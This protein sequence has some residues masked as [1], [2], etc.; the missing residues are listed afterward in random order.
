M[1]LMKY[2]QNKIR[3]LLVTIF[4]LFSSKL[5][6]LQCDS[7]KSTCCDQSC[8]SC[9]QSQISECISCNLN[10]SYLNVQYQCLKTCPQGTYLDLSLNQ[11]I[12]C[13]SQYCSQCSSSQCLQC[14][15]GFYS[16]PNNPQNCI[17]ECSWLGQIQDEEDQCNYGCVN[18]Q[19]YH[20]DYQSFSCQ[21]KIECPQIQQVPQIQNQNTIVS[22]LLDNN[23]NTITIIDIYGKVVQYSY[24]Y[25]QAQVGFQLNITSFQIIDCQYQ[26]QN[27]TTNN[28][29]TCLLQPLNL[30]KFYNS[31]GTIISQSFFTQNNTKNTGSFIQSFQKGKDWNLMLAQTNSYEIDLL[32]YS[33]LT[34]FK[35]D[36]SQTNQLQ[37]TQ[38]QQNNNQTS[39]EIFCI[40]YTSQSI[41]FYQVLPYQ[42][43]LAYYSTII[44]Q[45]ANLVQLNT[46]YN[47][48]L[49][50]STQFSLLQ[51]NSNLKTLT[52]LQTV[53][54]NNFIYSVFLIPQKDLIVIMSGTAAQN[55]LQLNLYSFEQKSNQIQPSQI[56]FNN[57]ISN[58]NQ[59]YNFGSILVICTTKDVK[60]YKFSSEYSYL[61]QIEQLQQTNAQLCSSSQFGVK[62]IKEEIHLWQTIQKNFIVNIFNTTNQ[63]KNVFFIA[64]NAVTSQV[65]SKLSTSTL[66]F[67]LLI[68]MPEIQKICEVKSYGLVFI[69]DIISKKI[70]NQIRIW[71]P[72]N[73]LSTLVIF[74]YQI[75][76]DG[77]Y[78]LTG[79]ENQTFKIKIINFK[80][81]EIIY[82]QSFPEISLPLNNFYQFYN[83]LY[84]PNSDSIIVVIQLQKQLTDVQKKFYFLSFTKNSSLNGSQKYQYVKSLQIYAYNYIQSISIEYL[85]IATCIN[86]QVYNVYIY[87]LQMNQILKSPNLLQVDT[88]RQAQINEKTNKLFLFN[89][90]GLYIYNLKT[91][92]YVFYPLSCAGSFIFSPN[93]QYYYTQSVC[94]TYQDGVFTYPNS[95]LISQGVTPKNKFVYNYHFFNNDDYLILETSQATLIYY[96]NIQQKLFSKSS[97]YGSNFGG[98]MEKNEVIFFNNQAVTHFD[99]NTFNLIYLED[100]VISK[101]FI[102]QTKFLRF[103]YLISTTSNIVQVKKVQQITLQVTKSQNQ[104]SYFLGFISELNYVVEILPSQIKIYNALNN[105]FIQTVIPQQS[106]ETFFL[107]PPY[108]NFWTQEIFTRK[109]FYYQLN[110]LIVIV[111]FKS[112]ICI[113]AFT[114]QIVFQ[115]K[116]QQNMQMFK[117]IFVDWNR[118]Y[119]ISIH[120]DQDCILD[121]QSLKRTCYKDN[122]AYQGISNFSAADYTQYVFTNL[123]KNMLI[124]CQQISVRV[125]DLDSL[126]YIKSIYDQD[127]NA[128]QFYYNRYH[129]YLIFNTKINYV[130]N[131]LDLS[132]MQKSLISLP[133]PS[134]DDQSINYRLNQTDTQAIQKYMIWDSYKQRLIASSNATIY[135]INTRKNLIELQ[136]LDTFITNLQLFADRNIIQYST[137]Y[138][139]VLLDY[140]YLLNDNQDVFPNQVN[141]RFFKV[142]NNTYFQL[143]D[144][145]SQANLFV[146]QTITSSWIRNNLNSGYIRMVENDL[147]KQLIYTI[148]D[149]EIAILDLSSQIIIEI[150][151][152]FLSQNIIKILHE[153]ED[154]VILL[155][156]SQQ[157]LQLQKRQTKIQLNEIIVLKQGVAYNFFDLNQKKFIFTDF[158][159]SQQIL[160]IVNLSQDQNNILKGDTQTYLKMPSRILS[161]KQIN[162]SQVII[163]M[164]DLIKIYD[165]SLMID[166]TQVGL[167][168]NIQFGNI[169]IDNIY[170][171]I[172]IQSQL[173]GSLIFDYNLKRNPN[174]FINS[175]STNLKFDDNF[176]YSVVY[177]STNIYFRKDLK[178]VFNF[179]HFDISLQLKN[180]SYLGVGYLFLVEFITKFSI[181]EFSPFLSLPAE[182]SFV[183]LNQ[184]SVAGFSFL[185][186]L[187]DSTKYQLTLNGFT[188]EGMFSYRLSLDIFSQQQT[189][190][191]SLNYSLQPNSYQDDTSLSQISSYLN[192]QERN[193]NGITITI[194]K[195]QN[196][197]IPQLQKNILNPIFQLIIATKEEGMIV[198]IQEPFQYQQGISFLQ[199]KN[200]EIQFSPQN[201]QNYLQNNTIPN[202]LAINNTIFP[203]LQHIL[204]QN[205][206]LREANIQINNIQQVVIQKINL[207]HFENQIL[208]SL[209]QL[210]ITNA[211]LVIVTE[212]NILSC[213]F[214]LPSSL[215][216]L[217]DIQKLQIDHIYISD[218]SFF[219]VDQ[220]LILD[221]IQIAE[222]QNISIFNTNF[223]LQTSF[224]ITSSQNIKLG[225]LYLKESYYISQS[226]RLLQAQKNIVQS[227][228][229][230]SNN[231][232][233]DFNNIAVDQF[234]IKSVNSNEFAFFD[235][236]LIYGVITIKQSQIEKIFN[237]YEQICTFFQLLGVYR[238][239]LSEILIQVNI[240]LQY[241][242][243]LPY[244]ITDTQQYQCKDIEIKNLKLN[245]SFI[246]QQSFIQISSLNILLDNIQVNNLTLA[247]SYIQQPQPYFISLI[248]SNSLII[249]NSQFFSINNTISGNI[250]IE[251]SNNVQIINSI[252]QNLTT[253]KT[254]TIITNNCDNVTI[255]NNTFEF[256]ITQSGDGGVLYLLDSQVNSLDS[257]QFTSNSAIL[258]SGGAIYC[259]GSIFATLNSNLFIKNKAIQSSGGAILLKNCDI[260]Q[261]QNNM[262]SQNQAFI[263]GAIRY[264]DL[265]PLA[266]MQCGVK[267]VKKNNSF[268]KNK[269]ISFGINI[270]SYP[271]ILDMKNYFIDSQTNSEGYL[272]DVQSGYKSK[273]PILMRF[274]D[275]EMREVDFVNLS[276]YPMVNKDIIQEMQLYTLQAESSEIG[277]LGDLRQVYSQKSFAFVFDLSYSYQPLSRATLNIRS[278]QLLPQFQPN[279]QQ[280]IQEYFNVPV[281]VSFRKCEVGEVLQK[282]GNYTLCYTCEQGFYSISDPY[283][284]T[285]INC[286]KC[287][288]GSIIC[289]GSQIQVQNGFWRNNNYS[290]I[291]VQCYYPEVCQ[292]EDP[293][294]KNGCIVG[295]TGPLCLECDVTGKVWGSQYSKVNQKA[296]SDCIHFLSPV[297][298]ALMILIL[299]FFFL[300]IYSKTHN[301]IILIRKYIMA[302]YLSKLRFISPNIQRT[303]TSQGSLVKILLNYFQ[304]LMIANSL[305]ITLPA[306]FTFF[307][308]T[309]GDTSQLTIYSIDCLL[310]SKDL[311]L[312]NYI[313][314]LLW[315]NFQPI[316]LFFL[317]ELFDYIC[318]KK[319]FM[320]SQSQVV[321]TNLIII[322][323]FFQ[324]SIVKVISQSL[325][326]QKIGAQ[327]YITLDLN[328]TC[329]D[330]QHIHNHVKYILLFITPLGLI[331]ILL[332]PLF[333]FHRMR[334]FKSQMHTI[335]ILYRYGY[336]YQEYVDDKYYWDLARIS[337]RSTAIII[338]NI[339]DFQTL[340]K[341]IILLGVMFCYLK[342]QKYLKPFISQQY[343]CLEQESSF[344][345]IKTIYLLFVGTL[346]NNNIISYIVAILIGVLNLKYFFKMLKLILIKPIPFDD[347][348]RN[349]FEKIL[350]KLKQNFPM[351]FQWVVISDQYSNRA[352]K[353]WKKII[354]ILKKQKIKQREEND[355]QNLKPEISVYSPRFTQVT[356]KVLNID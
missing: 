79:F 295:H 52:L 348:Q 66:N 163:L 230:F 209:T 8:F 338:I 291:I 44:D 33:N 6:Q 35:L 100:S 141:P 193:L 26:N 85:I 91:L 122:P 194:D 184:Y 38:V 15:D 47:W 303:Q 337:I 57:E 277:L 243:L 276:N 196:I 257:N 202:Q 41:T 195:N 236:R 177:H 318:Y 334:N 326:C 304:F 216:I 238:S 310:F 270:G 5:A 64:Q 54:I 281:T 74:N 222:I 159:G 342:L 28:I 206:T 62:I 19:V 309:G 135:V 130:F 290:D 45:T 207:Q 20:T 95:T 127:L 156:Q 301:E 59:V 162:N 319:N 109:I 88:E 51:F 272:D 235:F 262:F 132:T 16:D 18:D 128:A 31:N 154:Q 70:V 332:I 349:K 351:F 225:E 228:F 14:A 39:F 353:R 116:Y 107:N 347:N 297:N 10:Y 97:Q 63:Q 197:R 139:N 182:K 218:C 343:N 115:L 93:F 53:Q 306:Y 250:I 152:I 166:I 174:S 181:F 246:K 336:L 294:S 96:D 89:F 217:Q 167:E 268:Y 7:S 247:Q 46:Y 173:V 69:Y 259:E 75:L 133:P 293:S 146:N 219:G 111:Y 77:T 180:I 339:F 252:F 83:P 279:I 149:N 189:Q 126:T 169:L 314:R 188:L 61:Q 71:Y 29:I 40:N 123:Q 27:D 60:S 148:F 203:D 283:S 316:A 298:I 22:S 179:R 24:P 153:N 165:Y 239:L 102:L 251:N 221:Q 104:E 198:Y 23:N 157:L 229:Q 138:Q 324:P 331:W 315:I 287:P 254:G 13:V 317:V 305:D 278:S 90:F 308:L 323:M 49:Y 160:N 327:N 269:A 86:T 244:Q 65:Q 11:C 170:Q 103:N 134:T 311:K 78:L 330:R 92:N 144:V 94:Q 9:S 168:Y 125:F 253:Y 245:N 36:S 226:Q 37:L 1:H 280:V 286:K 131:I 80:T 320:H 205:I 171:R 142:N 333:L 321:Y 258:G 352:F 284:E 124:I 299:S 223:T 289:Q 17:S 120:L 112:L 136:F 329:L 119:L 220:I 185:K 208:P 264:T 151:Q 296:C 237:Q 191:C 137:Y 56:K 190:S 275:E 292:P 117:A 145:N 263:G 255:Q 42:K 67:N 200:L 186:L 224:I 68:E 344:L 340:F 76:P 260:L 161:I 273:I 30:L 98:M 354:Q 350:F 105:Q 212:I 227:I 82:S 322:F 241:I 341:G 2:L 101:Q 50:T 214:N 140:D 178:L 175:L 261:I 345:V 81:F 215:I 113:D 248:A 108:D 3:I 155:S 201:Y 192:S 274:I 176:I 210:Q 356:F 288:I 118:G 73:E 335:R 285:K 84:Y 172:F 271:S 106:I 147:S 232:N 234:S 267:I 87:D 302:K 233:M 164:T 312:P 21:V 266:F 199:I 231:I 72:I 242:K 300:Q 249:S 183:Q 187:G 58:V 256:S 4:L 55:N 282:S 129:N 328:Y 240:N 32:F 43:V 355:K 158:S 213:Q 325:S 150:D 346:S 307:S 204:L 25:L 99:Q 114:F 110:N 143:N 48:V 265:Q 211:S 313:I 121:M 34:Y 12:T